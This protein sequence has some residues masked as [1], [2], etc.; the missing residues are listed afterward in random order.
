M[1][2]VLREAASFLR[3]D[4]DNNN[5]TVP[6]AELPGS[7]N[8]ANSLAA[9]WKSKSVLGYTIAAISN[10]GQRGGNPGTLF[11]QNYQGHICDSNDNAG[12]AQ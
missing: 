7:Q 5:E 12:K 2:L 8:A 1:P 3:K 10:I 4:N 6:P 9:R 11:P